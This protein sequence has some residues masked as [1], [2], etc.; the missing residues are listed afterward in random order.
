LIAVLSPRPRL[1]SLKVQRPC[2]LPEQGRDVHDPDAAFE[3]QRGG[4]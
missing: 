3:F 4:E 2:L 1:G